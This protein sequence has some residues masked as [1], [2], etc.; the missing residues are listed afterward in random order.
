MKSILSG[1]AG[2][3]LISRR[4]IQ[5]RSRGAAFTLIELLVVIA[6][7]AVL[8]GLLLP[9]LSRAKGK[10]LQMRC[11]NNIRQA[12]LATTMYASDF[13]EK[14]PFGYVL[15]GEAT[16]NGN[17]VTGECW[18]N[19]INSLGLKSQ[20]SI[21]KFYSCPAASSQLSKG[22]DPRTYGANAGI[23]WYEGYLGTPT[24]KK[25]IDPK[26]PSNTMLVADAGAAN[27]GATLPITSYRTMIEGM[28]YA[29]LF[30]HFGQGF[31]KMV[32][33]PGNNYYNYAS[34]ASTFAFFD[35]HADV[36][37]PD[38]TMLDPN[39]APVLPSQ[40]PGLATP[41]FNAFWKGQ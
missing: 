20:A 33:N 6:I 1:V 14:L 17:P 26:K 10:A 40:T 27:Y 22:N 15:A 41:L 25:I 9:A 19:F 4:L 29:P 12:G 32:S 39:R 34:G 11:L 23:A 36:R 35:G 18:T 38:F 37:K 7:I 8:A 16:Q 5:R 31:Q 3:S 28:N 24:L 2:F 30:P 21:T 13:Q